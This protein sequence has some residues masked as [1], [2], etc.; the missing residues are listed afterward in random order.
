MGSVPSAN[1]ANNS[2]ATGD[3]LRWTTVDGSGG[4]GDVRGRFKATLRRLT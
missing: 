4:A 2:F 3:T 1:K